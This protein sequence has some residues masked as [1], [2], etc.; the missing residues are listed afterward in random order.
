MWENLENIHKNYKGPWM[1]G[2]N[3]NDIME[4]NEKFGGRPLNYNREKYLWSEIST[5]NLTD[6]GYKGCKFTWSNHRKR[7]KGLIMERL[8][9]ILGNEESFELFPNCSIIHLPKTYSDHNP[10]LVELIP[11][12]RRDYKQPFCLESFWCRHSDFQN[13]I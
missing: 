2:E 6:I 1:V 5:C 10:L 9:K 11:R 12:G 4:S 8:D 3:F 13:L 7:N